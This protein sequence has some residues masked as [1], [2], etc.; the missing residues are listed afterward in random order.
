[1][2]SAALGVMCEERLDRSEEKKEDEEGI[3]AP[4]MMASFLIV[5]SRPRWEEE[6]MRLPRA[7]LSSWEALGVLASD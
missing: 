6:V 7:D 1:M 5:A 4:G 2:Y 3:E